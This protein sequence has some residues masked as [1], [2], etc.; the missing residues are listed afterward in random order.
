M[1]EEREENTRRRPWSGVTLPGAR[2][3][4]GLC[5]AEFVMGPDTGQVRRQSSVTFDWSPV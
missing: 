2:F 4:A 5:S 3:G 1:G